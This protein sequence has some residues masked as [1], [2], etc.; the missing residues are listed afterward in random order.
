M[1][2]FIRGGAGEVKLADILPAQLR[3]FSTLADKEAFASSYEAKHPNVVVRRD[4]EDD[5]AFE[6]RRG[7]RKLFAKPA[8]EMGMDPERAQKELRRVY[9]NIQGLDP[10]HPKYDQLFANFT[11]TAHQL[12]DVCA[13]PRTKFV[14]GAAPRK[15]DAPISPVLQEKID[16]YM[17]LSERDRKKVVEQ[18]KDSDLC[19]MI[20]DFEPLPELQ[21]L[22]V[23]RLVQLGVL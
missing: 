11:S 17:T 2:G 23:E 10:K 9:A 3:G 6:T 5:E 21:M 16:K 12:E 13:I 1:D 18:T 20:R 15:N 4:W 14:R 22:A 8:R 19:S 7:T